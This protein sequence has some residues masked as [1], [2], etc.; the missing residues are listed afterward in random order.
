MRMSRAVRRSTMQGV[1]AAPWCCVLAVISACGGSSSGPDGGGPPEPP[2]PPAVTITVDRS[3][4][5]Q[6]IIGWEGDSQ[7]TQ[8][9]DTFHQ[10]KD[11][12]FDRIV[13]ELG[14]NRVRL[15]VKSGI[16]NR[17]DYWSEWRAGKI[18]DETW[19]SARYSTVNDNRDPFSLEWN[20]F[21]FSEMDRDVES[22][23]QPLRQ[24]LAARG[25]R[26]HVNLNYVA[27][28]RQIGSSGLD[29]HH[30]DSP[31]EYAEFILAIYLHLQQK[32]GWVPDSWEVILEPDNTPFW[33]GH[34]IGQALAATGTR[35]RNHGFNAQAVA[36]STANMRSAVTYFDDLVNVPG[37]RPFISLLAYHRY[38]GRS[39]DALRAIAERASRYRIQT[40]MLEH[41]GSGHDDLYA[42]LVVGNVSAW[43]QYALAGGAERDNGGTYYLVDEDGEIELAR[44]AKFLRQYFRF[45]RSGATRIDATTT[46]EGLAP[47]AF[48]NKDGTFVVVAAAQDGVSFLVQG[49]PQG[50]YGISYTT[51]DAFAVQLNDVALK[52]GAGLTASIPDEGVIT[53]YGRR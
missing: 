53:V 19:R 34:Q 31:E 37:V 45:I 22:V 43:Q 1:R 29:Y 35:L 40:G 3:R 39:A 7:S 14:I 38:G 2:P 23:V 33:R 36:P 8:D 18:S 26:L 47:V 52:S 15:S 27:F 20:G 32:Y 50:T 21:H 4:T 42:D 9:R 46:D 13:D 44:R 25:E 16:E 10:Y 51:A 49:L 12:L 6:T 28:T 24:R 5:Y 17:R 41:I 30:D 11:R 48:V